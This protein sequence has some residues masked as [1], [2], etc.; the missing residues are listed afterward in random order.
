[1]FGH[2]KPYP[3]IAFLLLSPVFLSGSENLISYQ[4]KLLRDGSPVKG[5]VA[6]VFSI[7]SAE[8]GGTAVW[9]ESQAVTATDGIFNVLLGSIQPLPKSIF[10]EEGPLYLGI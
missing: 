8:M 7:Y 2:F 3:I 5:A 6:V 10:E 1:M 9:S 4:G